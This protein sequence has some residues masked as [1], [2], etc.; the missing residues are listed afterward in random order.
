MTL[1]FTAS[2]FAC[3]TILLK[4]GGKLMAIFII[5]SAFLAVA[6]N[7]LAVGLGWV[8][9]ATG[10]GT[11]SPMISLMTASVALTGGPGNAAAFGPLAE[12]MG[13]PGALS[14]A[15]ASATFGLVSACL[16]GG[17]L[18]NRLI[19]KKKLMA[20]TDTGAGDIAVPDEADVA[21]R[22]GTVKEMP[23]AFFLIFVAT[24]FGSLLFVIAKIV[25]PGVTL[26]IHVMGMLAGV[27]F[28]IAMDAKKIEVP[29]DTI[30]RL[31]NIF[32]GF[33][34]SMAVYT[35]ALWDLIDLALP[36]II[37]LLAQLPLMWIIAYYIA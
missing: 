5:L 13:Y 37:L 18:G 16:M 26:P 3:S 8:I 1:F 25:L 10:I 24:G 36:L 30:E 6:Q 12:Q 33:F 7:L 20:V 28:R 21:P 34:V 9:N 4:K 32:L 19:E 35:M 17:P 27:L 29:E 15:I 11:I 14:V 23:K 31:G 22:E 2:G